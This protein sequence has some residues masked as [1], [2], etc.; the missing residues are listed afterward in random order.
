MFD[1]IAAN[2]PMFEPAPRRLIGANN[3][4]IICVGSTK[5]YWR[6]H[7]LSCFLLLWCLGSG[8]VSRTCKAQYGA[9][10]SGVADR[11]RARRTWWTS[12]LPCPTFWDSNKL[13]GFFGADYRK[14][15]AKLYALQ[16][17]SVDRP[18]IPTAAT[19]HTSLVWLLKNILRT[20]NN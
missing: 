6:G 7:F 5:W 17:W 3:P 16:Q 11:S 4:P 9:C 12:S 10:T 15:R 14:S 13:R 19:D 2:C 20:S 1:S 18:L 8:P